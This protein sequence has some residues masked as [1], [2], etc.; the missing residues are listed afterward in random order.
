MSTHEDL[1]DIEK[2]GRYLGGEMNQALKDP[3]TVRVRVAL[4]FPDIYEIGMS[5]AG[6]KILY[7]I[8]NGM[9]AVWAQRVFAP[10]HDMAAHMERQGIKLTTLEEHRP[11][12]DF[13]LLGFSLLY[14]LSYTTVV[15]MLELAGIPVYAGGRTVGDPI[16]VAGGTCTSNPAPFMD[17]FDLVVLGDGEEVIAEM[18]QVC[19]DLPGRAERIEAMAQLEGVYRPGSGIRAR[20]RI[21]ADL[22]Q[23]PFPSRPVIP[24]IAIVHDRLGVEVA[25]GCTRGC[26]FCQAGMIYRP[27][28]ERSAVSVLGCFE[29]GLAATGY[30]TVAMLALSVTDLSYL[31]ALMESLACPG[32]E[33]AVGVPSMRVEGMS[34]RVADIIA[35]VKKPGF[36][37]APEAAT[38]RLR[39]VINK[40]NTEADLLGSVAMITRLG[41]KALKLYFMIGLPTEE[42]ADI[43]A[44][45]DLAHTL[46]RRFR[47]R[48]TLSLSA[49]TPKSH[50]PFQWEEQLSPA[51]HQEILEYLRRTI[52]NRYTALKWQEPAL[53]FLE[54]VFSRGDRRLAEVVVRA[55]THGAYLDGWG[56]TFRWEA[57]EQAFEETGIDPE[58]YLAP[59]DPAGDLPWDI[60]DMRIDKAFLLAERENARA[61]RETPDCRQG[62]CT[63]CGACGERCANI[64]HPDS[65]PRPLFA[66]PQK[67]TPTAYVA[68]LTKEGPLRFLGNRDFAELLKRAIRRAGLPAVYTQGFSP[69]LKLAL[70]PPTSFGIASLSEYAQF[71]LYADI[72]PADV[73]RRLART[74][75]EGCGVFACE[76]GAL[77][78]V[79]AYV[80]ALARPVHL[81]IGEEAFITKRGTD[82]KV[83]DFVEVLD[84]V[85]LRVRFLEGRT[86]SPLAVFEAC[87]PGEIAAGDIVKVTTEFV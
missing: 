67:G 53:S 42:E 40:G 29:Q 81:T 51:R 15:R 2:P 82:L 85:T 77:P 32:R 59:R 21:L 71:E 70:T 73:A 26:R 43:E 25:R 62:P 63:G 65:R 11:V 5:H 7:Q 76:R 13:D 47:G 30:D 20:R 58:A 50:T 86:L 54:G 49:F 18:A 34:P 69:T 75:P 12:R 72:D 3:Q 66:A 61:A 31:N 83:L 28:R 35:A 10:W 24:N 80:F 14:E 23:R 22:D 1:F 27:Y 55:A 84:S 39:R 64:L 41:W 45:V 57:W 9:D 19:L 78:R 79:S 38:E 68:G 37:L 46:S 33:I 36:T 48:L 8:L 6:I 60:V 56:D 87:A 44:I 17:F 52:R 4:A 74:L 16:V